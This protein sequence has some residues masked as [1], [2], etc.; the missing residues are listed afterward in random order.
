MKKGILLVNLGSPDSATV[1]AVRRYLREFLMDPRVM[2]LTWLLRAFVVYGCILPSRP[3]HSAEAYG[4]IWTP[5]GAPLVVTSR[6]VQRA[7]QQ[8]LGTD[9]PVELAMR[10]QNPS[11][12]SA[13]ARL[14][15]QGVDDLLVIPL[16]PQY[17][18]SSYEPAALRVRELASEMA[19]GMQLNIAPPVFDD[20]AYI[21]ALAA[22]A[23]NFLAADYDHLLLS[24]HGL[25]ER[26]LHK[27]DPTGCHCLKT[28]DCC[29]RP[30]TAHS[31]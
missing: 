21:R 12:S 25:P 15:A 8:R 31:R 7:L 23:S 18:M 14:R 28:P 17:A 10:S 9:L 5:E 29:E 1:P 30:S 22:S 3:K 26:H 16:F 4:K 20:P 19:P 24:F 13:V 6:K 27:T 2:D 11:I